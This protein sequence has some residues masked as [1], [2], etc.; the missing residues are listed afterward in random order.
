MI[1]FT[2]Q[3]SIESKMIM[4][5]NEVTKLAFAHEQTKYA[6]MANDRK[7]MWKKTAMGCLGLNESVRIGGESR[8]ES[9]FSWDVS[10]FSCEALPYRAKERT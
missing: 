1:F 5:T 2:V 7:A 6:T 8:I 9:S 4:I 10:C 3:R